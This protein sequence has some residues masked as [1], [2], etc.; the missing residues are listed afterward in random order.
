MVREPKVHGQ[1]AVR[2]RGGLPEGFSLGLPGALTLDVG[3]EFRC[4]QMIGLEIV[5]LPSSAADLGL[6]EGG[7][8]VGGV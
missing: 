1:S 7:G 5:E 8:T 2:I 4:A 3:G 6:P